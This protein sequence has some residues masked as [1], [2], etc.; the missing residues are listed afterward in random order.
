V[1]LAVDV[2]AQLHL[3]TGRTEEKPSASLPYARFEVGGR[4]VHGA[5]TLEATWR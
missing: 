3:L 1:D 4:I 5:A 2:A